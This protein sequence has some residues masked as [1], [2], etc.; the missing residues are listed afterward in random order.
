MKN[1]VH[2]P[3]W[4]KILFPGMV[5]NDPASEKEIYLTFDDGPTPEVT[6]LV[7]DILSQHKARA[8]FFCLG[9][10]IEDNPQL[11]H[12]IRSAGHAIGNHG[13]QHLSG[14]T[15]PLQKYLDNARKG[16]R[17]SG[18]NLYRPPYGRITLRQYK[19]L[20]KDYRLIMWSI[21]SMDFD[22]N[23]TPEECLGNIL[24]HIKPGSIVVFH[25]SEKARRNVLEVLPELL[26]W[27]E[28]N[29]YQAATIREFQNPA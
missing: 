8:T 12:A 5:W 21:M 23:C 28:V 15:T 1:W 6:P 22:A 7:L 29:G 2:T 17:C 27:M 19:Q 26:T 14:F 4:I 24:T 18:S 3:E 9:S 16:E 13:Y 10:K 20:K 25:D 11:F